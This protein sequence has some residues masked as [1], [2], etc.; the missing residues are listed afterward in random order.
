MNSLIF[1]FQFTFTSTR[2]FV[3]LGWF[4]DASVCDWFTAESLRN[5]VEALS[6]SLLRWPSHIL[7]PF[8]YRRFF[9]D[10][11]QSLVWLIRPPLRCS[12]CHQQSPLSHTLIFQ[13]KP[14]RRLFWFWKSTTTISDIINTCENLAFIVN[15]I[16]VTSVSRLISNYHVPCYQLVVWKGQ[17][18]FE[19]RPNMVIFRVGKILPPVNLNN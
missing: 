4:L 3:T 17:Y 8:C 10:S 12:N 5:C 13:E 14:G 7:A 19:L 18:L 16:V 15:V 6:T 9:P 2:L 1:L 11:F